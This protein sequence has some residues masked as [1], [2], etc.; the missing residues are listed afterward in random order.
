MNVNVSAQSHVDV[1]A[2]V[3]P[4]VSSGKMSNGRCPTGDCALCSALP[5]VGSGNGI[6]PI[7]THG[8][9]S[10][11]LHCVPEKKS[12]VYRA[13]H[14]SA[15]ACR[16]SVNDVGGLWSHWPRLE[17]MET[18]CMTINQRIRS[19][20]PKGR[21]PIPRRTRRNFGDTK[22]LTKNPVKLDCSPT[23]RRDMKGI[24]KS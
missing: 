22:S 23:M 6:S 8:V 20:E 5:L 9:Y 10:M 18:N 12:P 16:L 15:I 7:I 3:A 17:I 21:L 19:L 2:T 13:M 11:I 24:Q 14:L 1:G 4:H